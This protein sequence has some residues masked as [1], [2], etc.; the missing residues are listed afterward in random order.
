LK[1]RELPGRSVSS[2]ESRPP[3]QDSAT[4]IVFLFFKRSKCI[5]YVM[6]CMLL[7]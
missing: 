1:Y 2:L 6:C 4:A 7:L 3:V 5:L